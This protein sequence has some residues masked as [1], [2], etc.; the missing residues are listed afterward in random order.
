MIHINPYESNILI[1]INY[2]TI[3][4]ESDESRC[5]G[6]KWQEIARFNK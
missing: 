6:K 2:S 1:Q 4:I 3:M 5:L